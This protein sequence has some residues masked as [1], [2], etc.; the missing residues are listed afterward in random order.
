MNCGRYEG[1]YTVYVMRERVTRKKLVEHSCATG[2]YC[3]RW[4]LHK[5][6]HIFVTRLV[7][8][9]IDIRDIQLMLGHKNIA[10]AEKYL[11]TLRMD[12]LRGR[13]DQSSLAAFI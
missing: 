9:G 1:K 11:G 10:T 5:F 6:R 8:D 4:Y 12:D 7:E 3:T 2:P 13:I